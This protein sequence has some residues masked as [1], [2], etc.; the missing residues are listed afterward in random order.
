MR[1][2]LLSASQIADRF[3]NNYPPLNNL[4]SKDE[5]REAEE[6]D[7]KEVFSFNL[8]LPYRRKHILSIS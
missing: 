7:D 6:E 4:D 5:E 8:R 3:P 2:D 1:E